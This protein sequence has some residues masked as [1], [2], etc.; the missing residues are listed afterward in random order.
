MC[1]CLPGRLSWAGQFAFKRLGRAMVYP[2]YRQMKSKT[3]NMNEQLKLAMQWWCETLSKDLCETRPWVER[4][5]PPV[6]LLCDARSTP[7]R[8]AAVLEIDG[9]LFYSDGPPPRGIMES[10]QHRE[11]NQI[12]SLEILSIAFGVPC[13][14]LHHRST[15]RT[16]I[17]YCQA[18]PSSRSS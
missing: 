12:T 7:P 1:F 2:L 14:S 13:P 17:L 15:S 10:F 18:S 8:V 3:G 9:D 6:H 16:H 4:Q 5:S 11:D